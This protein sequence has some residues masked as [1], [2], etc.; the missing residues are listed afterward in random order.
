[1]KL[2]STS[3][4]MHENLFGGE[5]PINREK[6]DLGNS[7]RPAGKAH[8][9][10]KSKGHSAVSFKRAGDGLTAKINYA[11][12]TAAAKVPLSAESRGGTG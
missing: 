2:L 8:H 6:T 11:S 3:L 7:A 9:S 10:E 12:G 5:I 1:M 4:R